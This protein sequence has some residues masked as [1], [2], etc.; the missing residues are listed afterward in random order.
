MNYFI[1]P[2]GNF[3]YHP[4]MKRLIPLLAAL[5]LCSCET[6]FP[7]SFH[8]EVTEG[9]SQKFSIP[10]KG[11]LYDKVPFVS[12]KDFE[13]YRSFRAEDGLTYGVVFQ[14]KPTVKN[15]I[16]ATTAS[17]LGSHILPM[18]NGHPMEVTRL[19]STPITTGKLVVWYGF[20]EADLATLSEVVPPSPEEEKKNMKAFAETGVRNLSAPKEKPEEEKKDLRSKDTDSQGRK[21]I[22]ERRGRF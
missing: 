5:A 2:G 13:N 17:N 6:T 3:L 19:Y 16:E 11:R 15:R 9:Q 4:S 10:N 1:P 7:V 22:S 21:I 18:V 20:T 14:A 12:Q 8:M